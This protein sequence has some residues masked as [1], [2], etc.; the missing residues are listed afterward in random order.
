MRRRAMLVLAV[1]ALGACRWADTDS[2]RPD[3]ARDFPRAHREVAD[4]VGTQFSSENQR[5]SVGEAKKVMDLAEIARGMTVADIGAGEGYYT[6]R[7]AE[8][9]GRKGRVLAEDIDRAA[10]DRLGQRVERERLENVSIRL[11]TPDDPKL[12]ENSFD[13]VFMVHM[14]HEVQEPYAFLWRLWPSLREGGLVV[15]VD[16]DRPTGQHGIDPLLLSCEFE[17]VGFKLDQFKDAP[18]LAGYYAQFK[19]AAT[20][21]EPAA[22]KPCRHD[23]AHNGAAPN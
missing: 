4:A 16:V 9:V 3:T 5:D 7:L 20:R 12:P 13:R 14:Y 8:R 21:P 19:R 11:G 22:I 17:R 10:L 1:L 2:S 23:A 6:V 15:V 18:E